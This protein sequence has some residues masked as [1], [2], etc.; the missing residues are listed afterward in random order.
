MSAWLIAQTIFR[1]RPFSSTLKTVST[2]P[3]QWTA[4]HRTKK[5]ASSV[6]VAVARIL[7]V[8]CQS[9]SLSHEIFWLMGKVWWGPLQIRAPGRTWPK[10]RRQ[11]ARAGLI[12]LFPDPPSHCEETTTSFGEATYD[13]VERFHMTMRRAGVAPG[14]VRGSAKAAAQ[15]GAVSLTISESAP[16]PLGG[17]ST[18][19]QVEYSNLGGGQVPTSLAPLSSAGILQLL[20][21]RV[22][23][24]NFATTIFHIVVVSELPF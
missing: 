4:I 22:V 12:Q 24:V 3:P 13:Y 1:A 20:H 16:G 18:H 5:G 15:S 19:S 2:S 6:P 7:V 8:S 11:G 14:K 21:K 10:S 23:V 9:D 17:G